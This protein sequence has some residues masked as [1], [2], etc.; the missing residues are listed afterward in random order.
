MPGRLKQ[1]NTVM[2]SYNFRE[3]FEA[4]LRRRRIPNRYIQRSLAELDDHIADLQEERNIDMNTAR[5]PDTVADRSYAANVINLQ[6]RL[7]DPTQLAA[8]AAQQYHNRSFLGRHPILTF[9]T[10]PLPLIAVCSTLVVFSFFPGGY[11]LDRFCPNLD[12]DYPLALG[13]LLAV[14]FWSFIVIPPLSV[15]LLVCR[16]GRRNALSWRWSVIACTLVALYC[17]QVIVQWNY[18][19]KPPDKGVMMV[20]WELLPTSMGD[21]VTHYLPKFAGAMAIGLLLIQRAKQLQKRDEVRAEATLI[22]VAA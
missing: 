6:E 1:R 13:I 10:L 20:G 5:K 9:I 18:P 7:G 11:L 4:E 15:F 21:F 3:Q 2:D 14:S 12:N 17:S 8:F 16:I 19:A 22:R